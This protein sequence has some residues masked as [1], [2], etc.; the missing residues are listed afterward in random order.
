MKSFSLLINGKDLDTGV[1]EYFPYADRVIS[2]FKATYKVIMAVKKGKAESSE[3]NKH[4]YAQYCVGDDDTNKRAIDAAYAASRKFRYFPVSVRRKILGDIHQN[5]L[6]RKDELID[7]FVVEGHPRKLAEWE[8]SGMEKAYRKESLDYFKDELW[9]EVGRG[10]QET[11]YLAR[12]PDGVVCVSPPKNAPCSNSLTVGFALL[13]GNTVIVKPPLHSPLS[14]IFLWKE[15]VWKAVKDNGGPDGTI[16][17]VIGNSKN[18]MDEWTSSPLVND[19]VFFGTSDVGLE[20]GK[21]I[22]ESGKKPILELSGNDFMVIW[23]DANIANAVRALS[24]A[25]LGSTQICMVPKTALIHK[26]IYKDF[27]AAFLDEVKQMKVG[28][29][30][31]PETCLTPV[32]KMKEFYEFLDDAKEKGCKV[33]FGGDRIDHNGIPSQNGPYLNPTVISFEDNTDLWGIKCLREENFFPLLPLVRI[34]S[35]SDA[36]IFD[37]MVE[38]LNRNEYGLRTSVWVRS[39]LYTRKFVRHIHNSGLLRINSRHVDFSLYL[40]THGGTGRTGGP[41]GE[42]NYLW[43]KT[44]HLQGISL[45]RE[46][47]SAT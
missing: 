11:M 13:G 34:D 5:L 21:R 42:M 24:D 6:D 33:L 43:Q 10:G 8:F 12:K 39:N 37:S 47:F 32:L 44:T 25:F 30:S 38:L 27:T 20:I 4:I 16:N 1:Y 28:L 45:T 36:A 15:I 9:E 31:D 2:D 7:I 46:K 22:Y 26:D 14:T 3:A 19:I 23:K 40:S 41:Y 35:S 18:I 29:P 17:I